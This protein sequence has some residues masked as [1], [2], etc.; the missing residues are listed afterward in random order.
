MASP[1]ALLYAFVWVLVPVLLI[2]GLIRLR[3]F[4]L[5]ALDEYRRTRLELGKIAEEVSLIRKQLDRGSPS[6]S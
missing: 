2:S 5:K 4:G 3:R 1:L 6:P